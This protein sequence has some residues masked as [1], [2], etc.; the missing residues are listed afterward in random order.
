MLSLLLLM[1]LSSPV[2]KAI[3]QPP[4]SSS[5][6]C[7]PSSHALLA[8]TSISP[9]LERNYPGKFNVVVFP[10]ALHIAVQQPFKP[11]WSRHELEPSRASFA[12][13]FKSLLM[14]LLVSLS[15]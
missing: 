9:F 15:C 8:Y 2:S 7:L 10:F 14:T 4:T 3:Q 6:S 1:R 11:L 13:R 5:S 12:L